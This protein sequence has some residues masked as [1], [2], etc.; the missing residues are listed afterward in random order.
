MKFSTV[1][2]FHAVLILATFSLFCYYNYSI[3]LHIYSYYTKLQI[4][5]TTCLLGTSSRIETFE[6]KLKDIEE[7]VDPS[8]SPSSSSSNFSTPSRSRRRMVPLEIRASSM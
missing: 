4:T 2:L 7:K 5:V 8:H 1:E 6:K 3:F